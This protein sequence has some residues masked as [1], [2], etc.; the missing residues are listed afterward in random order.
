MPCHSPHCNNCGI[1]GNLRRPNAVLS[2]LTSRF[3]LLLRLCGTC[4]VRS[5]RH[6]SER[7]VPAVLWVPLVPHVLEPVGPAVL[8]VQPGFAIREP[9]LDTAFALGTVWTIEEGDVLI[10]DGGLRTALVRSSGRAHRPSARRR[11]L[12]PGLDV[13]SRLRR[14]ANAK[15]PCPRSR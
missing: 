3:L 11:I 6:G 7:V 8:L 2:N 12:L 9:S 15:S 14:L 5:S 4:C 10:S 1:D 13:R